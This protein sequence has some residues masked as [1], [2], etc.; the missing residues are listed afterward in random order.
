M[1]DALG[2]LAT[3]TRG[4]FVAIAIAVASIALPCWAQTSKRGFVVSEVI[5]EAGLHPKSP[6][7]GAR[8]VQSDEGH[9]YW[10]KPAPV[11]A[12]GIVDVGVEKGVDGWMVWLLV[13]DADAKQMHKFTSAHVGGQF[14]LMLNGQIIG[15]PMTIMGTLSGPRWQLAETGRLI[16]YGRCVDFEQARD[17]ANK[18]NKVASNCHFPEPSQ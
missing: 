1:A 2:A 8:K 11:V 14:A 6:L 10:V 18:S 3:R 12:G 15:E 7:P 13:N 16:A 4:A 9:A 17:A 5:A